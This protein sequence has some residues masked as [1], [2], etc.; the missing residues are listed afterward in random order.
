M[1]ESLDSAAPDFSIGGEFNIFTAESNKSR[2]LH[3]IRSTTTTEINIDL[4]NVTEIDTTGL[5]LMVMAK[6]EAA[7]NGKSVR[8]TG[9]SEPVLD[10]IDLCGLSGFFGDPILI[11][12]KP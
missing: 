5:Q 9:H 2:L 11:S 8:F 6:R 4:S 12:S 10:L 7:E 1:T 3:A